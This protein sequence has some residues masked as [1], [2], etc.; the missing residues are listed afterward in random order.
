MYGWLNRKP[1]ETSKTSLNRYYKPLLSFE[2]ISDK[3]VLPCPHLKPRV[4]SGNKSISHLYIFKF[5]MDLKMTFF[6]IIK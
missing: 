6:I 4:L 3:E 2:A 1:T 5:I